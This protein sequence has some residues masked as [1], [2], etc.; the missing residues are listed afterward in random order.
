[1]YCGECG[2]ECAYRVIDEGIGPYEFWGQKCVDHSYVVVSNC[3]D[4]PVYTDSA[5]T[6]PYDYWDY[7]QEYY[8]EKC[9]RA[10]EEWVERELLND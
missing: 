1:M 8:D 10:Y 9:D 2:Q 4:A 6:C 5:L 7:E 3:C